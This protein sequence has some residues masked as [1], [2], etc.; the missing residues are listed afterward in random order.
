MRSV[1]TVC[2]LLTVAFPLATLATTTSASTYGAAAASRD[3]SILD[4]VASPAETGLS[5][6]LDAAGANRAELEKALAGVPAAQRASLEWLIAH[7]PEADLRS[8]DAAF[9]LAHVDGAYT[10]WKSAPWSASIDEATYLDAIL[11]YASVSEKRELW[12]PTLRAKC[13]P[14]VE[15]LRDPALAAARLNQRIFPEFNVAYS[16]K[17]KRAD[18][19]PSESMESGLASCSGLSI[20]LID[21]CRSVG[22]PARFVGVPMWTDGSGNHSWIEVWDGARWRYTG[23]AEPTGDDLDQGWFSGRA[24]G[25]NR[26]K[27]EHAIYAVTWRDTGVDFPFVF[28][29]SRPRARAVDV[30][31]RY[32]GKATAIPDGMRVLRVSVR[33]PQTKLRLARAVEARDEA[34]GSIVKGMSKDERFDLNDH[35]ELVVPKEG[36][37][38]FAVDGVLVEKATFVHAGEEIREVILEVP[39]NAPR[40]SAPGAVSGRLTDLADDSDIFLDTA[41]M[42]AEIVVPAVD[43]AAR[44]DDRAP[45]SGDEP[46]TAAAAIKSLQ[47]F[48]KDGAVADVAAQPFAATALDA[49][50]GSK[51]VERVSTILVKAYES[52]IRRNDQ[53]EFESKVLVASDGT[54]MPFWYA[55]YG[56]K[57]KTGRS[58][59]ISMHGGGGAPPQVNDQQWENQKKLYRPEEG[60]YVAP[61]APTDTWNLWHQGHIDE[62]FRELVRDMV[63]FEDVN[64][65]RVY[66]MGYSA[67]GDGVYQLAP[68]MADSFAA[69]AMMAGHPNETRPDGLRNLPFALF[70]G[71]KDA[72]FDRNNIARS[73]KTTLADLAAKDPG[74]Y[75]HEVTIYEENGH[76]M[77]RKDAVGVPWMAKYTRNLRPERIVWLQDDV[78]SPRFY[79]LA[80][81]EPKGGQ[82]VVAERKGQE[83]T[84]LEASG[85]SRLAIRLDGSMVDLAK[86]VVVKAG[87]DLG[88]ATLFE[89]VVPATIATMAKTLAERG[90]PNG[91][92]L[93]EITIDVPA[94]P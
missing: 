28:D 4:T 64:P 3:H 23:A 92:F 27:P 44:E 89:G 80:N 17:R 66:V 54:K 84:I 12:L 81:P 87:P 83:I 82:R 79:W 74:G 78:T 15:G 69:A 18:Q 16:T 41:F 43:E 33:D 19:S 65:D 38:A 86:P 72:A 30:T 20:L 37:V 31:D 32:A 24:S 61:R 73:W 68:R 55:V 56:D 6:A 35:L 57:P 52:Q 53:K 14:M 75:P 9:L 29:P 45:K 62:L 13:L 36:M 34:S 90:D 63:V 51:D 47:A 22:I 59:F 67:G 42:P 71:G 5:R 40:A 2:A 50:T 77:D 8:L 39:A 76:W 7:M 21:A 85:V 1:P 93:A 94:K 49:S 48:V 25:Q 26:S 60:V 46:L 11:P 91:V 10:A 58:L 88:G 70:M